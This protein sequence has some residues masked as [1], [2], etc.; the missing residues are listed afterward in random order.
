MSPIIIMTIF[1]LRHYNYHTSS[2]TPRAA[3]VYHFPP[4]RRHHPPPRHSVR[5]KKGSCG[6]DTAGHATQ[7]GAANQS[8]Q[9]TRD[10][11]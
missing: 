7:Q 2:G 11:C 6:E 10:S 1:S 3:R 9:Q 5:H 8:R 4:L